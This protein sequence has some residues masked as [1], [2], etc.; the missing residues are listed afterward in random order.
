MHAYG[1][2]PLPAV[3]YTLACSLIGSDRDAA[4]IG[5]ALLAGK[6]DP[7]FLAAEM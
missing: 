6:D 7:D 2:E 5:P 3:F 1:E 4:I